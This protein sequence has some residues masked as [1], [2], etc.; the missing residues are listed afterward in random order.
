MLSVPRFPRVG[1]QFFYRVN[2]FFNIF[3][4]RTFE[5][6]EYEKI[7]KRKNYNAFVL[8][9]VFQKGASAS[10]KVWGYTD[11]LLFINLV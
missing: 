11:N 10:T 6:Y 1:T 9:I 3:S 2:G 8:Q 5:N 7:N 4:T